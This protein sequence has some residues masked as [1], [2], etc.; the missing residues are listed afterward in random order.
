MNGDQR[1]KVFTRESL[2]PDLITGI[3]S[4]SSNINN[5]A[6]TLVGEFVEAIKR[7]DIKP[8]NSHYIIEFSTSRS[9]I[10]AKIVM[11]VYKDGYNGW[12]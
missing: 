6:A 2:L 10:D 9:G 8:I 5:L 1:I 7:G 11:T 3:S 12:L 4:N